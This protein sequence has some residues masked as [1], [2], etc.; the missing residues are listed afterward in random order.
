MTSSET[1][2]QPGPLESQLREMYG[3]VAYTHKTHLK[4]ADALLDRYKRVK[5]LEIGLS[6]LTSSALLL[7]VFG[8][9]RCGTIVGAI[10]S[11]IFLGVVLYVK[12]E[13]MGEEGQRHTEIAAK[14]WGLREGLLS[15][16]T[17]LRGSGATDEIRAP[18]LSSAT[19]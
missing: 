15:L 19:S 4:M 5:L 11:T 12:E 7:A 6:A 13:N 10:L 8:D 18:I 14:L 3:R 2:V 17:D 9:S 16:L 1:Q